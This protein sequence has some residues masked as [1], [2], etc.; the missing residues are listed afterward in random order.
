MEIEQYVWGFTPEGE[1]IVR[2]TMRNR[3]GAELSLTNAGAAV[4]AL[5]VPDAEGRLGDVVLGY[6]RPDSYLHDAPRMGKIVG[7]SAGLIAR[8]R[9]PLAGRQVRLTTNVPPHH[10]YGGKEGF[11]ARLWES[12]VETNRVVFTL[13]SPEGDQGY[14][15]AVTAEA[16]YDWDEERSLEITLRAVT[17]APTLIDL[18]SHI[19]FNLAGA[20]NR[21]I[22]GHVLTLAASG[23]LAADAAGAPTGQVLAVGG[24]ALDFRAG[25]RLGDALSSDAGDVGR[26]GG[27]DHTLCLDGWQR[28]ILSSVGELYDPGSGRTMEILT[29][30]PVVHLSTA[31]DLQGASEGPGGVV[32]DNHTGVVVAC[33]GY[34]DAPNHLLFPST[35]VG[36]DEMYVQKTVYRFG[37]RAGH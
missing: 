27:Y 19:Y 13:F 37:V 34:P 18:S 7:R 35:L 15:G 4:A 20:D 22:G 28:G 1:A 16:I 30:Q 12:R 6:Q 5:K 36:A 26:R 23:L 10:I 21:P 29:T 24:T 11:D 17:S 9:F 2:Y 14:P 32:W 33:A 25:R 8:G 31:N 3:D